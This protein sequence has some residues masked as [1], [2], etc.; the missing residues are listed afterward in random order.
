MLRCVAPSP[1]GIAGGLLLVE[2]VDPTGKITDLADQC[3]R[4]VAAA[5]T[6][7]PRA[8]D[9]TLLEIVRMAD[10]QRR[11]ADARTLGEWLAVETLMRPTQAISTTPPKSRLSELPAMLGRILAYGQPVVV[12]GRKP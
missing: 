8:D 9:A 3:L 5:A 11:A 12:E 1:A 4:A 10:W 7:A 6:Q 2:A